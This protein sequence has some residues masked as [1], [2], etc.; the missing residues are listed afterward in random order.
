M[1]IY[2]FDSSAILAHLSSEPGAKVVD[3]L[4][5][6]LNS[7]CYAHAINLCEVYY[8]VLR[9]A[10]EHQAQQT[11]MDYHIYGVNERRDMDGQFWRSVGKLKAHGRISIADCFSIALAQKLS[12]EV[13][14]ADHHE[15]DAIV[16]LGIVPIRFI[17]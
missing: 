9:I 7:D 16:P 15:F 8:H 6:D 10:D 13:V 1:S 4:L 14:T 5:N 17:R 3:A 12:G 2:I 11:I